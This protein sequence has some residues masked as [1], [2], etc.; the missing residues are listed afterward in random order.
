[1]DICPFHST[2]EAK[3]SILVQL[4]QKTIEVQNTFMLVEDHL[5]CQRLCRSRSTSPRVG[6]TQQH[7]V[8]HSYIKMKSSINANT[9][10]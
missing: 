1:M 8:D 9:I 2:K 6:G 10:D 3:V 7:T 5:F 4:V